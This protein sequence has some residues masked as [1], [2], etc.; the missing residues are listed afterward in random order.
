MDI[1]ITHQKIKHSTGQGPFHL[2][3]FYISM[4]QL[5]KERRKELQKHLSYLTSW[6]KAQMYENLKTNCNTHSCLQTKDRRKN[7]QA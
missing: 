5:P 1:Y 2:R 4:I 6:P 3:V 7:R